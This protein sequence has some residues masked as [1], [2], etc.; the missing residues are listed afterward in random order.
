MIS[1]AIFFIACLA[2]TVALWLAQLSIRGIRRR[3][4]TSLARERRMHYVTD[5]RFDLAPRVA[6]RLPLA[7]AA[8]VRVVDLIYGTENGVRHYIFSAHYTRGVVRWKRRRHCVASLLETPNASGAE[9]SKL[10]IAPADLPLL[11][12]YAALGKSDETKKET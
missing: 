8:D 4:L 11:D 6:E 2:G 9:W 1:P 7:G 5:D 3:R 10:A 12:Q